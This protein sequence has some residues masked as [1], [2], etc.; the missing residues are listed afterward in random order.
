MYL[1]KL[2]L[3]PLKEI[4]VLSIVNTT[5][6]RISALRTGLVAV[7]VGAFLLILAL[8]DRQMRRTKIDK[9]SIFI[10]FIKY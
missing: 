7:Y 9:V 4:F 8:D 10:I 3:Q 6:L 5:F 2:T 1:P